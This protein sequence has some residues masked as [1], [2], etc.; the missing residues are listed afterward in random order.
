MPSFSN[1]DPRQSDLMRSAVTTEI[2][3]QPLWSESKLLDAKLYIDFQSFVP[4]PLVLEITHLTMV[5]S[6]A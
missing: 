4:R 5:A 3:S 1:P 2:S 6:V